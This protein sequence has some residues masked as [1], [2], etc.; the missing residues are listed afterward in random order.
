LSVKGKKTLPLHDHLSYQIHEAEEEE[1]VPKPRGVHSRDVLINRWV[2]LAETL[3]EWIR[4][5]EAEEYSWKATWAE[6]VDDSKAS[7]GKAIKVPITNTNTGVFLD[8]MDYID[9]QPAGEYYIIIRAKVS[10]NTSDQ[11]ILRVGVLSGGLAVGWRDIKANEFK[12]INEY[13][14]FSFRFEIYEDYNIKIVADLLTAGLADLHVDF[15][16]LIPANVPLAGTNL[17]IEAAV[18]ALSIISNLTGLSVDSAF[19]LLAIIA[20]IVGIDLDLMATGVSTVAS[21][22]SAVAYRAMAS[23]GLLSITTSSW[24]NLVTMTVPSTPHELLCVHTSGWVRSLNAD[25]QIFYVKVRVYDGISYYP[26]TEGAVVWLAG[27]STAKQTFVAFIT[28]P[29]NL[30]GKTIKVQ[31]F[32]YT[33]IS[34]SGEMQGCATIWGHSQH[35]HDIDDPKHDTTYDDP[36]HL[37]DTDEGVDGHAHDT[38]EYPHS[39]DK[40]DP[41]HEHTY[42]DPKHEH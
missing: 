39:H 29:Q 27:A 22:G 4:I 14:H 13:Q 32:P 40:D 36:K 30:A 38:T 15:A 8:F 33:T 3:V 35:V 12:S 1:F 31:V 42:V 6:K 5:F 21:P 41:G 7:G 20:N 18:T 11:S 25:Y 17:D 16:A 9:W 28:I 24:N 19:T 23:S 34:V 2:S 37:H 10:D 26:A